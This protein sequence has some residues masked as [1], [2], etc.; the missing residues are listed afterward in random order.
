MSANNQSIPNPYEVLGILATHWRRLLAPAVVLGVMAAV[1]AAVSPPTWQASQA[2][3]IRNEAANSDSAQGKFSR[4]DE[5]KTV[6]ETILELVKSRVVLAGALGGD[7]SAGRLR[8]TGR[9]AYGSRYRPTA[10]VD[11]DDSAQGRR[12]RLHRGLLSGGVRSRPRHGRWPPV[13]RSSAN[14][15]PNSSSFATSRPRA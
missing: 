10:A 12:V 5:M 15:R 3:M 13:G 7:R 2:L 14:C 6:Q 4:S 9:L 1:Y 11:Q 8:S